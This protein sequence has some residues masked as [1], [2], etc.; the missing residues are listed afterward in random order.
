MDCGWAVEACP[1]QVGESLPV[2]RVDGEPVD[3][4]DWITHSHGHTEVIRAEWFATHYSRVDW[5]R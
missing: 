1:G 2:L 4:G 5:E 3:V